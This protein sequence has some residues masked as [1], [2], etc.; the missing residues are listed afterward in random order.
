MENQLHTKIKNKLDAAVRKSRDL[1][2]ALF[3]VHSDRSGIH[4][5]FSAGVTG[6]EKKPIPM[7]NPFHVA[8]IGKTFTSTLIAR[9]CERNRLSWDD[10]ITKH[11][12]MGLLKN[13]FVYRGTDYSGQVLVRQLLNHTSGIAD[14][15]EDKPK[16]GKSIKELIV[17]DPDRFWKPEDTFDFTRENME[18]FSAPG[19]RFHYSD[20]GYNILGKIIENVTEKPLFES[21]HREIF[22]PLGM[23]N[24]CF[25]LYSEPNKG[26]NPEPLAD[27]YLGKHN[28]APYKSIS[29]DWAGGGIVSTT[30]D[31][32]LFIQ[33]LVH[34]TLV[35][36]GTLEAMSIDTGRFGFGMTYGYGLLFLNVA[37]MALFLPRS[38]NMWGN[39]GSIASYMFYNP[40]FD[41]YLTGTFNHSRY[42]RRQVMF[43]IS[44]MQKMRRLLR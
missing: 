17:E 6:P 37:K 21:L 29:I 19:E 9:L 33:A 27:T 14:Y 12:P 43:L 13:L 22:D 8:S 3:L 25:H 20:T 36:R 23:E 31:L 40:V 38:L 15:F 39:L 34:N 28:V 7:D 5:K 2:N 18:A 24:S 41:I 4:W 32:L 1:K 44:V 42:V 30:E 16:K 11:L 10:P 26:K 35:K